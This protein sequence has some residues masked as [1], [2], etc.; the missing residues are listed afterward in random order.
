MGTGARA[1]KG[2]VPGSPD[3]P[4]V[5]GRF[6]LYTD[7]D[8]QGQVVEALLAAGWDVLRAIDAFPERI[9]DPVHFEEAA[10]LG[11]VLV[12]NDRRLTVIA[13]TWLVEG[14][15]FRGMITWPQAHYETASAGAFLRA[16]EALAAKGDP[17]GSYPI[18]HLMP[19]E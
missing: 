5:A 14:R 17:F 3:Q 1:A 9:M 4:V 15:P 2:R 18:V 8:V 19:I 10:R 12:S 6:P 16:F 7:A 11:R 13:H